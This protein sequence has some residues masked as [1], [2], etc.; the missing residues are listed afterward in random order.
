V[1]SFH[2]FVE[3]FLREIFLTYQNV[4]AVDIFVTANFGGQESKKVRRQSNNNHMGIFDDKKFQ[5]L[6]LRL[7]ICNT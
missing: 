3:I 6:I 7:V 1:D 2:C 5:Y 4:W